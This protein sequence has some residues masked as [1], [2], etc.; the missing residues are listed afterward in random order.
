VVNDNPHVQDF[1]IFCLEEYKAAHNMT[2][3]TAHEIFASLGAYEYLAT[4]YDTL[5][6]FGA[7]YLISDLDRFFEVRGV[8]STQ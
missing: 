6:S 8:R 7:E 1:I 5:H 4:G 2:G 3:E